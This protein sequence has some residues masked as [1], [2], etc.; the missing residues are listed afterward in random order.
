MMEKEQRIMLNQLEARQNENDE[1]ILEGYAATYEQPTVLYKIGETEYKEVIEKGAFDEMDYSDCCL[2]Y[3]HSESVP[4]LARTKGGSL[5]LRTDEKGLHF[6]AT[7]FKT[8]AAK[9]VYSL[10]RAGALDKCSFAFTIKEDEYNRKTNT[11]HIRKIDKLYDVAVV[12]VPAYN[13]TSVFAR[14]FFDAEIEKINLEKEKL[15]LKLKLE[16]E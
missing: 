12:D 1:M 11:R 7:L 14:S 10:V 16:E 4:F 9:D 6:K 5:E 2:R 15:K 3:N 8:S 13:S